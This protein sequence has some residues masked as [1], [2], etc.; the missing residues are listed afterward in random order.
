[1]KISY[2]IESVGDQNKREYSSQNGNNIH[3]NRRFEGAIFRY[4]CV[5]MRLYDMH[6]RSAS[7]VNIQL[8]VI[9]RMIQ[10]TKQLT[11]LHHHFALIQSTDV[12]QICLDYR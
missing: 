6:R 5:S 7:E 2:S 11:L 1:M 9:D 10:T 8:D 12:S 3:P 4:D